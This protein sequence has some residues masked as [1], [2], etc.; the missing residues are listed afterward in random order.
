M[1]CIYVYVHKEMWFEL[2]RLLH[3]EWKEKEKHIS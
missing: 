2:L 1:F 3:D